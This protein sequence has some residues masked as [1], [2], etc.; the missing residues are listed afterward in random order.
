MNKIGLA[1][2]Q[3]STAEAALAKEWA[4]VGER[5]A[6]EQEL[7]YN[8]RHFSGQCSRRI[9]DLQ[10]LGEKYGKDIEDKGE[11]DF[12]SMVANVRHKISELVG[13]TP[14]SGI[15]LMNDLRLL[16]TVAEATSFHWIVLGQI[17]QAARDQDMLTLVGKDHKEV[18]TQI[19]F[20]KTLTKAAAPQVFCA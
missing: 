4:H 9:D 20:I 5:E 6:V 2:S 16:Y 15:V 7:Y 1:L 14:E 3:T 17:A 8:A 18:L 12:F 13:R 11:T 19:K 10:H